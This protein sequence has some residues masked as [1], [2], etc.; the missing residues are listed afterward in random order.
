MRLPQSLPFPR[1][2][3]N[4]D[5]QLKAYLQSLQALLK[6][7]LEPFMAEQ[8][9]LSR[10]T[11]DIGDLLNSHIN[12]ITRDDHRQYLNI[13]RHD[14]TTRHPL[15]NVIPVSASP[16][17]PVGAAQVGVLNAVARA[18]HSH[19]IADGS[20]TT[21]KLANNAVTTVK[22]ADGSVTTAK[23]VDLSVTTPKLADGSVTTVKIADGAVT[24]AKVSGRLSP[25]KLP[26]S[27]T[28][29]RFLVVRTANADPTYDA[30]QSAD[31]SKKI[32]LNDLTD[33]SLT[34]PTAGQVLGYDG[35]TWKNVAVTGG[36]GGELFVTASLPP[37]T[38]ASGQFVVM[39]RFFVPNEQPRLKVLAVLVNP[40]SGPGMGG[41]VFLQIFN[42]TDNV[43]VAWYN[44]IPSRVYQEPGQTFLL[45]GKMVAF[46]LVNNSPGSQECCGS[47]SFKLIP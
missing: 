10:R 44:S 33:V 24:D 4:I 22:I 36:G 29:N 15:G 12:D 32:A 17:P 16:P 46:R 38:V 47:I 34:S 14:T 18:D 5:S 41:P 2:P 23:L 27:G 28:A 30:I 9:T 19:D 13:A 1:I 21:P 20:V 26:T 40:V 39:M 25:S 7:F 35:T 31:I 45:G 8:N 42:E 6:L 37:T 3:E 43:E 11:G